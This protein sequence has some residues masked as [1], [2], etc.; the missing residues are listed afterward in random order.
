MF[1]NYCDRVT[2]EK[3]TALINYINNATLSDGESWEYA[4]RLVLGN[5]LQPIHF[6]DPISPKDYLSKGEKICILTLEPHC[7]PTLDY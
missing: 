2:Q 1:H 5:T 4:V 3:V 6:I 7:A